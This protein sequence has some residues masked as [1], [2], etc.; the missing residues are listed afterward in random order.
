VADLEEI[1]RLI[2]QALPGAEVEM[3]DEGGGDHLRANVAAPQFAGR[4][5]IDQHRMVRAPVQHLMDDGTI[6]ALSIST[7]PL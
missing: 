2:R 6:H 3:V 4:S 7:R 1:E 5:R